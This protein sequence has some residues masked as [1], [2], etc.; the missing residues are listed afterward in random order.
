MSR[1]H[2]DH[3][4]PAAG[5]ASVQRKGEQPPV[6]RQ[7]LDLQRTVGNAAVAAMLE[8]QADPKVVQRHRLDPEHASE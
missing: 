7:V 4:T 3:D 8:R 5:L 2:Q 1:T 6:Q